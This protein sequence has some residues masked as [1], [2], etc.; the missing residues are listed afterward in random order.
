VNVIAPDEVPMGTAA[1]KPDG[2]DK[3]SRG[4]KAKAN[5]KEDFKEEDAMEID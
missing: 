1:K 4:R 2:A 5:D 3:K